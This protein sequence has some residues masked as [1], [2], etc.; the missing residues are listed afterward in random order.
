MVTN[1]HFEHISTSPSTSSDLLSRWRNKEL[2]SPLS[3][4]ADIQTAGRGRRGRNW[5]SSPENSLTFSIAYPF[6]R[7][8]GVANL[9]GLSLMCGLALIY[10]ISEY[11]QISLDRL[12]AKGLSLK[13]PND[14]LINESKLAG[15]LVEG[16]QTT[17]NEPTWMI[18]GVGINLSTQNIQNTD[19]GYGISNLGDLFTLEQSIDREKLWKTISHSF[20][21]QLALFNIKGFSAFKDDW[22]KWG[23]FKDQLVDLNQDGK[24]IAS[25]KL[26]G[27]NEEGALLIKV[28]N[29]IKTVHNGDLS[30]RLSDD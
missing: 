27:I 1:C 6:N 5:Q 24:A 30:L 7:P 9:S 18:I 2:T 20:I 28:G 25:G 23:A 19:S 26:L 29:E 15:I 11:F 8:G 3:L 4:M 21:E 17:P 14:I 10:G 12:K 16:G 22:N 13:W